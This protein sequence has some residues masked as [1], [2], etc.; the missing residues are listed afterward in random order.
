MFT[1]KVQG[2]RLFARLRSFDFECPRCGRIYMISPKTRYTWYNP[3]TATFKCTACNLALAFG[4]LMYPISPG[5][6]PN[7]RIPEDTVPDPRQAAALR[8][9]QTAVHLDKSQARPHGTGAVNKMLRQPCNC[10]VLKGGR[11]ITHPGC[12]VH[13]AGGQ[14]A[15][16]A[17]AP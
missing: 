14:P 12:P 10:Q 3:R 2:T 4:L 16:P 1:D 17:L 15:E 11:R 8:Q 5:G 6:A 9:L 13:G 7:V